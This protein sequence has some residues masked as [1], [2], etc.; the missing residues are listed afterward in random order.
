M[1]GVLTGFKRRAAME[2]ASY[3]LYRTAIEQA[4]LPLFYRAFAV[5]DSV[6]GRFDLLTL[7]VYLILRRLRQQDAVGQDLGQRLFDLMFADM[8]QNL[9]VM[10]VSDM[11]VG[12]RVKAMAQAFYGRV[13]AYDAGLGLDGAPATG[14]LADAVR[15]NVY[16]GAEH[17]PAVALAAYMRRCD[18]VLQG[19]DDAALSAGTVVF[20]DPAE[21]LAATP[22]PSAAP[23]AQ[24]D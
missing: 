17:A 15:R 7:H 9:R 14:D 18:A 2:E 22:A 8:D 3:S 13:A 23:A 24:T 21:V 6:D 4:R 11:R 19:Q 10:G 1:L 5:E 16:R 20:P 12:K